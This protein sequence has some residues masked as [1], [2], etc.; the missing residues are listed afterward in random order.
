M[1]RRF[2]W[3]NEDGEPWQQILR[4]TARAEF[5]ELRTEKDSVKVGKF[6]ITWRDSL[7]QIHNKINKAQMD[8]MKHVEQSR[9]DR[10]DLSKNNYVDEIRPNL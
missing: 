3:A 4:K 2:S 1:T 9:T 6:L 10:P 8:M 5:Q 7:R